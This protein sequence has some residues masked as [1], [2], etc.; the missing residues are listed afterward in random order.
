MEYYYDCKGLL[1]FK[2]NGVN[3]VYRK[4]LQGDIIGILDNQGFVVVRYVYNAWGEHVVK[5]SEG[6]E[7]IGEL[8][9]FRYRGYFY[10]TE[11]SF[12]YLKTR[13]YNP[14][15]CRF[16][17]M[18]AFK[19]A[20]AESPNGLNLYA[21]CDNNPVMDYD[22]CGNLSW[23]KIKK[24]A[25]KLTKAAPAAVGTAV[26]AAVTAATVGVPGVVGVLVGS[27]VV[28]HATNIIMDAVAEKSVEPE[29][30][31]EEAIEA[32]QEIV[33]DNP[34]IFN[35]EDRNE[36]GELKNNANVLIQNS[37]NVTSRYDRIKISNILQRVKENGEAFMKGRTFYDLSAEWLGHN[38]LNA[39]LDGGQIYDRTLNVNLDD[40]FPTNNDETDIVT[41]LL[42]IM[43]W[44]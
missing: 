6:Y 35:P 28:N 11:T 19:Y 23:K 1:G 9:P 8:N 20:D 30:T 12:Y 34:V 15:F 7:T 13:Y 33:G 10:D 29:Y 42:M 37:T 43:G 3:Y 2:Y 32:I 36:G 40:K 16:L 26:A 24:K 27:A 44:L 39:V 41:A 18:D 17:S 21:Y 4:N 25:K 14:V 31:N 38:A 5:A 22:P